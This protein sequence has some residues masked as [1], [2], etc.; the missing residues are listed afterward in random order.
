[1]QD[2]IILVQEEPRGPSQLMEVQVILNGE[3]KVTLPVLATLRN[4]TSQKIII[5]G[6]ELVTLETL[7]R[8]PITGL[9]NAPLAELQKLSLVLYSQG[10]LKGLNIPLL[11]MNPVAT[12][13][14]TFPHMYERT[15]FDNWTQVDWEQS[16]I[17]YS[18]GSVSAGSPY[19]VIFEI[20][21]L[22]LNAAGNEI[23]GIS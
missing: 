16:Y 21:Y 1:M 6:I 11:K 10:W 22:K 9:A 5:K 13:G 8:G 7:A 15:R 4:D 14:G 18:N 2:R 19:C 12:P 17:Q 23:N 3:G 20:Q